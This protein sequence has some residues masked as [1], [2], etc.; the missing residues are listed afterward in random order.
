[1][2]LVSNNYITYHVSGFIDE[3]QS[4]F[5]E[6]ED[7]GRKIL[8]QYD[9]CKSVPE[10]YKEIPMG[11]AV[12]TNK[13]TVQYL[14]GRKDVPNSLV[15]TVHQLPSSLTY[16]LSMVYAKG[17]PMF[18]AFDEFM[19]LAIQAGFAEYWL[20]KNEVLQESI[21]AR[22]SNVVT[23][24]NYLTLDQVLS[25]FYALMFG[26]S[27]AGISFLCEIFYH[28]STRTKR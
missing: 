27:V 25:A 7:L 3:A 9:S 24:G 13:M 10:C 19:L 28:R 1:M 22:K 15:E 18:P 26:L 21:S 20:K 16:K 8:E 6:N 4:Y 17:H 11:R 5:D 12:F 14:N 2:S 23:R